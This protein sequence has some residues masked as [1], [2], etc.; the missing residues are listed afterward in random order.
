MGR[1]A[2][3]N[4]GPNKLQSRAEVLSKPKLKLSHPACWGF[5]VIKLADFSNKMSD[6]QRDGFGL[7]CLLDCPSPLVPSWWC[8]HL[9][10]RCLH[11]ANRKLTIY[12]DAS[13]RHIALVIKRT[14]SLFFCL[15]FN[16]ARYWYFYFS[17]RRAWFH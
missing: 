7:S 6:T 15:W 16:F 1:R 10:P 12:W 11:L 8:H 3:T 5:L 17:P 4:A 13:V 2:N 14:N 9:A